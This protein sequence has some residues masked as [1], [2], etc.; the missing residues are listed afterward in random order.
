VNTSNIV[1]QDPIISLARITGFQIDP[2]KHSNVIANA[3]MMNMAHCMQEI[4]VK[5]H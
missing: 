5:S 3:H 4:I 1:K 2:L